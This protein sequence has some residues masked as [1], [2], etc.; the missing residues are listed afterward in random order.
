MSVAR[1]DVMMPTPE[2]EGRQM[3]GTKKR[4]KRISELRWTVGLEPGLVRRDDETGQWWFPLGAVA[5]LTT[6][7]PWQIIAEGGVAL[8]SGDEGQWYG[9]SEPVDAAARAT[10]LL[11]GRE[12]VDA[13]L[14]EAS[15]ELEIELQGGIAIR[16]F[17]DSSGHEG[18]DLYGPDGAHWTQQGGTVHR[19]VRVGENSYRMMKT[20]W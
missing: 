12:V 17:N 3:V 7:C 18:W 15:S 16:T 2:S 9:L 20:G 13:S 1:D 10:E 5:C 4:V 19:A 6:M 14:V 8:A 11:A